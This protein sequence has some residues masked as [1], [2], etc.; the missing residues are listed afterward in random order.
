MSRKLYVWTPIRTPPITELSGR[1]ARAM[2]DEL[3]KLAAV[4]PTNDLLVT[5]IFSTY[6]Y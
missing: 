4:S 5:R 6:R 2:R 3:E 1:A